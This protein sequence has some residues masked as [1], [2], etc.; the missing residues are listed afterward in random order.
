MPSG[1][2]S[3][4]DNTPDII[5]S[6]DMGLTHADFFRLLPAAMGP[7]TYRIDGNTVSG[8]INDGT[9][10]IRLGEQQERRIALMCIPFATVDFAF[11]GV[12]KEQQE[13]F[14]ANFDLRF[15]RGGG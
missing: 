14:K 10:E 5:Y 1:H 8:E 11:R 6:R 9:V 4:V 2:L 12:T 13:T 3:P 7:H 15:Q